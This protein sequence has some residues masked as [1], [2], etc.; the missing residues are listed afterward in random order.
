MEFEL[1]KKITKLP[2]IWESEKYDANS[3]IQNKNC[4]S[5]KS[6]DCKMLVKS[7]V[8]EY[9]C[10]L[11]Y[12]SFSLQLKEGKVI[13]N[14]LITDDNKVIKQGRLEA[15]KN[16]FFTRKRIEDYRI[17]LIEISNFIDEGIKKDIREKFTLFHDV[18]SSYGIAFSNLESIIFNTAGDSF[19]DKLLNC[20]QKIIDLYDSLDLVNSQLELIDVMVNPAAIVQ[21][22]KNEMNLYGLTHK[23]AKLFAIKASRN[24]LIIEMQSISRIPGK[25]FHNSIK[26]I[27]IILIENAIKYSEKENKIVIKFDY[28]NNKLSFSVSSYGLPV[29][30]E[31]RLLI[32]EKQKRGANANSYTDE[33]LG[34]GLYIAKNILLKHNGT[35]SYQFEEKGRGFGFNIFRVDI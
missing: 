34:M 17:D 4:Q 7:P 20:D 25:Y 3:L 2:F 26:L 6:M 12:N 14:G 1:F 27:P 5:C 21:G 18:R 10:K 24:N 31:D 16:Y 19:F 15:K 33:G 11:G 8:T 9:V 30:E 23:L 28:Y 29:K 35:I 13:L 22:T 32:F